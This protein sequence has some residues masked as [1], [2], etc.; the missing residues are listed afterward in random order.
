MSVV[1]P[2]YPTSLVVSVVIVVVVVVVV[3]V[4]EQRVCSSEFNMCTHI[5]T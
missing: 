1:N 3:V 5:F 4:A 2:I